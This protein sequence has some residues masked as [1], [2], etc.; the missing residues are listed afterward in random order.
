MLDLSPN[1][2]L[3]RFWLANAYM[4]NGQLNKAAHEF[5]QTLKGTFSD[6]TTYTNLG[7]IAGRLGDES[8]ELNYYKKAMHLNPES[9]DLLNN[10]GT[11]YISLDRFSEAEKVLQKAANM[12]PSFLE[13][14]KNLSVIYISQ[15]RR[16]EAI[17][18]LEY[19][20]KV[21]PNDEYASKTLPTLRK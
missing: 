15:N 1:M 17:Q 2:T 3:I 4:R 11:L 8:Q 18:L 13:P 19:V 16:T 21:N 10:I 6:W 9:P 20:L 5:Q 12:E 14:R 7:I